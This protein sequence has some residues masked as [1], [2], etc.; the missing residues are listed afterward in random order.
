MKQ[1]ESVN[2]RYSL[3]EEIANS[4]THGIG[5]LF[6][7]AGL[8]V[9]TAFASLYGDAW[10]IVA[11][12]IFGGTMILLY[13][14]STLY[15]SIQWHSARPLLRTLD[16]CAIFLLI[17]GTYTPF[18][19][20]N[21]RGPWGWSLFGTIWGLAIIGIVLE[22]FLSPRLR[23]LVIALYISM[24]WVMVVAIKPMLGAVAPGGLI[25]LL[26]GGLCYTIGVPLYIK[27]S[28]PFNHAIWH[29]FVLAGTSLH[30]FAI[31]LYVIPVLGHH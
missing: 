16:H 22:I 2:L 7:I 5:L 21:L 28:I 24:G 23:H 25:L 14:A 8:G 19:L 20:V 6:A 26:A 9:L 30:F 3:Y 17:A 15:H 29:L 4:I 10:H 1:I 12:S 11:C 13:T 27:K 18:T 31:L